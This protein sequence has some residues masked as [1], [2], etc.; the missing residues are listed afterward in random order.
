MKLIA[1]FVICNVTYSET[2]TYHSL[3]KYVQIN[4]EFYNNMNLLLQQLVCETQF[5]RRKFA[6]YGSVLMSVV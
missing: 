1:F 3:L 2:T 6:F 4:T 5:L